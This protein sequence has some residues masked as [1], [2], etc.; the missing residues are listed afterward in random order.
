MKILPKFA[1]NKIASIYLYSVGAL[2]FSSLLINILSFCVSSE[3]LQPH[4]PVFQM[5]LRNFVWILVCMEFLVV[6]FCLFG[7]NIFIR[8]SLVLWFAINLFI[9]RVGISCAGVTGGLSGY[10]G[11][12]TDAMGFSHEC[13]NNY[14][15]ILAVYLLF[16]GGICV[17]WSWWGTWQERQN[18]SIKMFC[19]SCGLHIRF[20]I[21]DLGR[22]TACP[23][24]NQSIT[25]R[26][27]ENLKI[28]CFFCQG[29][30]EF[31]AHAIGQ[32]THCPHCNMDITL[33][34]VA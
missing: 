15:V 24:C 13:A 2:L 31:P 34:E 17:A 10:T 18:P 30:I 21:E 14:F 12:I 20:S 3:V 19:W 4:E 1:F 26:K 16:G 32:K 5:P 8:S 7:K 28:T 11:S 23:K 6:Y 22:I 29:H 33:K 27:P 9:Y 25:L